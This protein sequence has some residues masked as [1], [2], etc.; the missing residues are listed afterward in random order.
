MMEKIKIFLCEIITI[1]HV[2]VTN[3]INTV[4]FVCKIRF[5]EVYNLGLFLLQCCSEFVSNVIKVRVMFIL[6]QTI[7]FE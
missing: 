7:E 2:T 6:I 1:I 3:Q 4:R 5:V